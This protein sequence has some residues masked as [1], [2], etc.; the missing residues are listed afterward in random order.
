MP[1]LLKGGE[2]GLQVPQVKVVAQLDGSGV[3]PLH[4]S[5]TILVQV[6]S[7]DPPPQ[8][9]VGLDPQVALTQGDKHYKV[10]HPVQHHVMKPQPEV[11]EEPSHEW[12]CRDLESSEV[13]GDEVD[14]L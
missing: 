8:V 1:P 7:K 10:H 11:A 13:E 6:Q 9:K 3:D 12:M 5:I 4:G 2:G 14:D